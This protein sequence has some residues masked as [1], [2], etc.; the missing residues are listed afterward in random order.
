MSEEEI[1]QM[2]DKIVDGKK[3]KLGVACSSKRA[4][5]PKVADNDATEFPCLSTTDV[6]RSGL[7]DLS[8]FES[9]HHTSAL[10]H[11][12]KIEVD[13]DIQATDMDL[14]DR[15]EEI[16]KDHKQIFIVVVQSS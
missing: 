15:C 6:N 8:Y 16:N 7:N 13:R 1:V 3:R 11:A 9:K 14:H 2:A 12:S 4:K 5:R 10:Q